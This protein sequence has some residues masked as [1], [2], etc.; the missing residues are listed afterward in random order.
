MLARLAFVWALLIVGRLI[1]LQIVQHG[2][3][4][5]LA[6]Q[7][8]EKIVELQAARGPIL[9]RL[10]QRLAMSLPV[11]SVCV[12][13]LKVPDVAVAS[14]I[15]SKILDVDAKALLR[16]LHWAVGEAQSHA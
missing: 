8:Q 4:Q 13:P 9:D 3:Y 16:N 12:D 5:R 15:L 14:E 10:G 1:Q 11:E 7:Q 6:L 2:E